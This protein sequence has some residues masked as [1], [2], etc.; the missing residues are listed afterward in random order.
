MQA[1]RK[2]QQGGVLLVEVLVALALF[3][4]ISTI[5]A[6]ALSVSFVSEKASRGRA[7]G[8]AVLEELLT[9]VR[10]SSEEHW[11][12]IAA[13]S[14]GTPYTITSTAGLLLI[15]TGTAAVTVDGTVYTR[16]FIVRDAG[17][18]MGGT[19][20]PLTFTATSSLRSDSGS[21]IIDGMVTWG[22]GDTLALQ[23][24]LTRWR[25]IV[26]G[27]TSWDMTGS[28]SLNCE[29]AT[30]PLGGRSNIQVGDKLQLCTGC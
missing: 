18:Q 21:L 5:I 25:N 15:A 11:D 10:A 27:Q 8:A 12:N 24:V 30:V 1:S 22:K 28:T 2:Q 14:R 13:L 26:C 6:Q 4:A 23:S 16:S 19:L 3:L 7:V 9:Q 20:T 29:S 17:R